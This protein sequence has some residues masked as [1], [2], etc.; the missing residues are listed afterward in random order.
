[1]VQNIIKLT[2]KFVVCE[3]KERIISLSTWVEWE[4]QG[5]P[6]EIWSGSI[7]E[8]IYLEHLEGNRR[9]IFK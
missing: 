4:K 7:L 9:V 5:I 2:S 6:I 1:M 8:N 3:V